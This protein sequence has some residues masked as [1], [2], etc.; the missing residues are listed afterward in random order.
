MHNPIEII[1]EALCAA[2]RRI[3][4]DRAALVDSETNPAD[5]AIDDD[6]KAAIVEYDVVL[7]RIDAALATQPVCDPDTPDMDTV[8]LRTLIEYAQTYLDDDITLSIT[9]TGCVVSGLGRQFV[10]TTVEASTTVEYVTHLA[11]LVV[12]G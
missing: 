7:A 10:C 6:A 5:G 2:H 8:P 12:E 9:S 3:S 1:T 11:Q 4:A